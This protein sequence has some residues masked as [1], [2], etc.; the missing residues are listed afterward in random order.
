MEKAADDGN[1]ALKIAEDTGYIWAKIDALELLAA[2]YGERAMLP[3]CNKQD[4]KDLAQR[5]TKEAEALKAGL[6]LTE[7]HMAALTEQARAEFEQQTA[8]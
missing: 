6:F 3:N 2:Y 8:D 5:Y 7:E 4:E 1:A